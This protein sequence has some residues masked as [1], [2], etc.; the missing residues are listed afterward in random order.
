MSRDPSCGNAACDRFYQIGTGF[1]T[2]GFSLFRNRSFSQRGNVALR[3]VLGDTLI[4]VA[5]LLILL[6]ALVSIDDRVRDR[7]TGLMRGDTAS[8]ELMTLRYQVGS[9]ASALVVAA[10]EQSIEHAPLVIFC[11]AGTALVLFMLRL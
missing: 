3:R 10:K 5:A 7:V 1:V 6:A 9:A 8:S 2:G 11:V 4:S